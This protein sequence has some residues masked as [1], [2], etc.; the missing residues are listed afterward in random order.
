MPIISA[1]SSLIAGAAMVVS[2]AMGIAGAEA[3][4]AS[5]A[6]RPSIAPKRSKRESQRFTGDT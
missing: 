4:A 1:H 3:N 6:K 2:D 5:W